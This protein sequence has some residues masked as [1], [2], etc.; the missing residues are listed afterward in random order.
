[1]KNILL[2]TTLSFSALA[3][4]LYVQELVDTGS[5]TNFNKKSLNLNIVLEQGMRKNFDENI[6]KNDQDILENKLE[7]TKEGFYYPKLKLTLEASTH[8]VGTLRGSTK[9]SSLGAKKIPSGSFGLEFDEYSVFNWGKD[10]LK[11]LNDSENLKRQ[12]ERSK[13]ESREFRQTLISEYVKNL[14][15]QERVNIKKDQ[16]KNTSFIYRFNRE[17]VTQGKISKQDYYQS[18]S[19]Y[20]R[21]QQ[22]YFEARL[23][24]DQANE[25]LA[26]LID[27]LPGTRY[28]FDEKARHEKVKLSLAGAIDLANKNSPYIKTGK[29]NE[30]IKEREY[31]IAQKDNLPLPKFSLNLGAYKHHFE[32]NKNQTYYESSTE[33]NGLEVVA[34]VKASWSLFGD[35]G[36]FNRRKLANARLEKENASFEYSQAKREMEMYIAKIFHQFAVDHDRIK[37]LEARIP[38]LKKTM[39]LTQNAYIE[40]KSRFTDFHLANQ[41]YTLSREDYERI[42]YEY[43]NNKIELA[44]LI[45]LEDLPGENFDKITIINRNIP[46]PDEDSKI[47]TDFN[48]NN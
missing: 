32:E 39:D 31:E 2:L 28:E 27:D 26:N 9:D 6:R 33:G 23:S 44:K 45:G 46:T 20:L 13:E 34:T 8:K 17:R 48:D 7:D 4:E 36:L 10:Y 37:I 1:M 15:L 41:E 16:L 19:E 21:A 14:Y 35:G 12:H 38:S 47:E 43:L 42:R 3:N 25:A 11:Y 40:G 24:S 18:R 5:N 29:I 30:K 22:E